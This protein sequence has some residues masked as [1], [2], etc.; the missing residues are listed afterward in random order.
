MPARLTDGRFM[1]AGY[2]NVRATR[3]RNYRTR[4]GRDRPPDPWPE[5]FLAQWRELHRAAGIT[6]A[7][8]WVPPRTLVAVLRVLREHGTVESGGRLA[9]LAGAHPTN[10]GTT[11]LP[12]L[13]E[14]A[15]VCGTEGEPAHPGGRAPIAWR[16]TERGRELAALLDA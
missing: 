6:G 9:R 1:P 10:L 7:W 4:T 16:L 13:H 2:D 12:R 14:L 15:L 11:T 8:T 5:P 3:E